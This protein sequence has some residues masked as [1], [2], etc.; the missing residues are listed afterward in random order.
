[1]LKDDLLFQKKGNQNL[2]DSKYL[3]NSPKLLENLKIIEIGQYIAA[4]FTS[5][6]LADLGASVIKIEPQDGD[7]S[8]QIGPFPND[9]SNPEK[10]G[11]FLSLNTSK[12]GITLNFNN[13][14]DIEILFDLLKSADVL[15]EDQS[16]KVSSNFEFNYENLATMYPRLITTTIT[17]FG[18]TG[19]YKDYKANDLVLFHMSSYAH[20]I[21]SSVENPNEEPPIR[22]GGHQSE[23][24][25]GLSAATATM[26]S[27]FSQLQSNQGTHIDISKLES[28]TMMPQGP[29]ADAAF[30]KKRQSRKA[31]DR[32]VGAI[33]AMLPTNDGYITISP[34]E[35]HQWEA[36]LNIIGNPKWSTSPEYNTRK[37]RQTNWVSL[38]KLLSEWTCS[39]KKEDIYRLCQDAHVPAF[40]VN[41]AADLF[42]SKQLNSREFY[43][44]IHHPIAGSLP[45]TGFPYKLSNATLK[46]KGPAP[47]LGQH[48][49]E[50][51]GNL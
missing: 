42:K 38:E 44:E 26:I 7:I 23:F 39:R 8:R 32:K 48:N 12:Q 33:V 20:I 35:D 13:N 47:T 29:I 2:K 22:A 24:V 43:Q 34:R 11:L 51:L 46:I 27:V 31:S 18:L 14:N 37:S 25:S 19:P 3:I 41:T 28:I 40:P 10:S 50:I 6:L 5:K 49:E 1:M 30:S 9:I 21:A 15:I 36:W 45:Y 4:P 17:P 16:Y